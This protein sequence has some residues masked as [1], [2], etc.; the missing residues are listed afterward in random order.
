MGYPVVF[1][2]VSTFL[3]NEAAGHLLQVP[4]CLACNN[5]YGDTYHGIH[6]HSMRFSETTSSGI[7]SSR[8]VGTSPLSGPSNVVYPTIFGN[9]CLSN[10][11]GQRGVNASVE[12]AIGS[13]LHDNLPWG[14]FL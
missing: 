14:C 8:P 5:F 1:V 10:T 6:S 9:T 7:A 13:R 3:R 11:C 2:V 4:S 12:Y